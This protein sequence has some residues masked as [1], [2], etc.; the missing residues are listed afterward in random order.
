MHALG[1]LIQSRKT[2]L[3][4]SWEELARRG[5]FSSHSILYAIATKSRHKAPP[6]PD[7]ITKIAKAIAV[8]VDVVKMAAIASSELRSADPSINLEDAMLTREMLAVFELLPRRE[9]VRA[10]RIVESLVEDS[11]D[12]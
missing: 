3:G 8:P 2:E 1:K 5:G 9:K 10:K 4:V 6:R 11:R 12:E 7:T